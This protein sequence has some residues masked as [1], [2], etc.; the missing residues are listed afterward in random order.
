MVALFSSG[1]T[2]FMINGNWEVPTLVIFRNKASSFDTESC[3][4]QSCSIIPIPGV[5]LTSWPF[6][7]MPRRPVSGKGRGGAQVHC[8]YCQAAG[9]GGWRPYRRILAASGERCLQANV[10]QQPIQ[11]R[12]RRPRRPRAGSAH[13]WCG[14]PELYGGEQFPHPSRERADA[15]GQRDRAVHGRIGKVCQT[16]IAASFTPDHETGARRSA[17]G[18]CA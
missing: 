7:T 1:R 2:A 6:R 15:G 14:Q 16:K 9:L 10:S 4:F 8:L 18:V 13:F 17:R 12:R 11:R 5:T 3:R